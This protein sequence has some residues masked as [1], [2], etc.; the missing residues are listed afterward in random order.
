MEPFPEDHDLVSFFE[1]A[2]DVE[3]A[4]TPWFYNCITFRGSK[5]DIHYMVRLQPADGECEISI[6]TDDQRLFDTHIF[7]IQGVTIQ[8]NPN[9]AVMMFT[10]PTDS[11]R[12]LLKLRLRPHLSVEWPFDRS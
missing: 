10:F 3:A 4:S 6:Y 7:E 2:P 5:G 12:G 1:H 11:A 8:Q 9:E